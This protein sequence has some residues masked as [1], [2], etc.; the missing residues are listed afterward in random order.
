[1]DLGLRGRAA[2]VAAA[3]KGIGRAC[4]LALAREGADVGICARTADA[5]EAVAKEIESFGVRA[6]AMPLDLAQDGACE[7][8]I[9]GVAEAF[10][11]LDVV[12]TNVGGPPPGTFDTLDDAE[13][14]R[15]LDQNFMVH[16]RLARAAIPHMRAHRWGR[17]VNITSASVKTPLAGLITG[18]AARA[19]TT[20][21]AKTLSGEVASDGIT[22]NNIAP[23]AVRTD[24]IDEIARGFTERTGMSFDEALANLTRTPIGRYGTPEE[25]AD[26]VA[27]L[28]SD[29]ASFVTGVTLSDRQSAV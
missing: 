5:L 17:I 21:W 16:V 19:A 13:F 20:A 24:R 23:E 2:A 10:G 15:V 25:L 4:A 12:V 9:A 22:V 29:R 28:A 18:N 7:L 26:V 3:S 6:H 14:R 8:F 27:F 1:M 11:R